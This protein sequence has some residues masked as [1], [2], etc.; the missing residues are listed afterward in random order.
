MSDTFTGDD[1]QFQTTPERLEERFTAHETGNNFSQCAL[2][3]HLHVLPPA[4]P[5]AEGVPY[6]KARQKTCNAFP[7]GIPN[8]IRY[9]HVLHDKHVAGDGGVLW[10]PV[11]E[12][13]DVQFIFMPMRIPQT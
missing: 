12:N 7:E 8:E 3:A 2:C 1:G 9:N 5:R 6:T 13:I 4:L 10:T 11:P